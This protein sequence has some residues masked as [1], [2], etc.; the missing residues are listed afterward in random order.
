MVANQILDMIMVNS[1]I[2]NVLLS[3]ITNIHP[4]SICRYRSDQRNMGNQSFE[5]I[6]EALVEL[7]VSKRTIKELR[8]EYENSGDKKV[9]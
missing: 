9:L 8:Q 3:K 7:E 1:R 2:S 6:C 4:S 5:K